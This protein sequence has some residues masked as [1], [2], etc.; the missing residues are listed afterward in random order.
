MGYSVGEAGYIPVPGHL[1]PKIGV[2]T[3]Y[4][5]QL[6]AL[7]KAQKAHGGIDAQELAYLGVGKY[8][9]ERTTKEDVQAVHAGLHIKKPVRAAVRQHNPTAHAHRH[10]QRHSNTLT[11]SHTH[12]H[13]ET[14]A[15]TK[16]CTLLPIGNISQDQGDDL[17]FSS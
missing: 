13:M 8:V 16:I 7:N 9:K 4:A 17:G 14:H 6:A 12:T 2:D 5:K 10:S 15:C 11:H 1:P 3:I